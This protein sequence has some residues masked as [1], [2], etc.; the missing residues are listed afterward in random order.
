MLL[1]MLPDFNNKKNLIGLFL[2]KNI[3][4]GMINYGKSVMLK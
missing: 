4:T 2:D 1:L 3:S